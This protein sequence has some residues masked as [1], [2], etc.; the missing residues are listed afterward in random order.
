MA[1]VVAEVQR[2]VAGAN[3]PRDASEPSVIQQEF[4]EPLPA[5]SYQGLFAMRLW[6]P[7]ASNYRT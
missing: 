5:L 1:P 3:L 4:S 2:V 7:M 6:W